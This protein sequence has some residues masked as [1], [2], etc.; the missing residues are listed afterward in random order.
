[1]CLFQCRLS[2]RSF[3]PALGNIS[4]HHLELTTFSDGTTKNTQSQ[5]TWFQTTN[6][7]FSVQILSE[8][9]TSWEN[10]VLS[11][12]IIPLRRNMMGSEK[13]GGQQQ[14]GQQ[15]GG[16]QQGGQQGGQQKPGQQNQTPGRQGG[17]QG[18]GGQRGGQHGGQQGQQNR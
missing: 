17:H 1:M 11:A 15:Q 9:Q 10:I 3:A 7:F 4:A 12:E 14:G 8:E 6:I 18:G 5:G 2:V 13:Q 16:Q